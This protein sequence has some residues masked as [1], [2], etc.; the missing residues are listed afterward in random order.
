MDVRLGILAWHPP[1]SRAVGWTLTPFSPISSL[2]FQDSIM[3]LTSRSRAGG[4]FDNKDEVSPLLFTLCTV[5]LFLLFIVC[6]FSLSREI[7]QSRSNLTR[8]MDEI[9]VWYSL[10]TRLFR[11]NPDNSTTRRISTAGA[12]VALREPDIAS[13]TTTVRSEE[14]DPESTTGR[15]D[16]RQWYDRELSS[17]SYGKIGLNWRLRLV[18]GYELYGIWR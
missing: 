4:I 3:C 8:R 12:T 7:N 13:P 10:Q 17:A 16:L 14:S 2:L 6:S 9:R 1:V 5:L 11:T 15:R 18:N